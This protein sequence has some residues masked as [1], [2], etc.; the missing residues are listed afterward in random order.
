MLTRFPHDVKSKSEQRV[1]GGDGMRHEKIGNC[2]LYLG[3]CAEVM[4]RLQSV[5]A[6]ITDPPYVGLKGNVEHLRGGV[7]PHRVRTQT[8]GNLWDASHDWLT[9]AKPLASRAII[10]F[11]GYADVA[12]LKNFSGLDG[13]LLT[14]FIRNSPAS[15]NNAPWFKNEFIWVLK[16]GTASWRHLATVYDIPKINAGCA[17]SP[18]RERNPDGTAA[19]PTQKPLALIQQLILPEFQTILDPFMGSGTAGVACVKMGRD[20]IGV[21]S[22]PKHFELACKRIDRQVKQPDLFVTKADRAEQLSMIVEE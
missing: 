14:W 9:I 8:V 19:H 20:F 18:E 15:V 17:G 13:W 6:I 21:E 5:D 2:D 16:T 22:D 4:P 11:C 12:S 1:E 7:G 3:D 10:S